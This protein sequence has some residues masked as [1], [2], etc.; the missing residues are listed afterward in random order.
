MLVLAPYAT[1]LGDGELSF[2]VRAAVSAIWPNSAY[3]S[4]S[5]KIRASNLELLNVGQTPAQC[6]RDDHKYGDH[7]EIFEPLSNEQILP[8]LGVTVRSRQKQRSRQKHFLA[9]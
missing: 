3:V 7:T 4:A 6:R 2:S 5:A 8:H 1:M 9:A